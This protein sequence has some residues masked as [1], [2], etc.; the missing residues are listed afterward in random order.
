MRKVSVGESIEVDTSSFSPTVGDA[1]SKLTTPNRGTEDIDDSI[2]REGNSDSTSIPAEKGREVT[3]GINYSRPVEGN[4]PTSTIPDVPSGEHG[5]PLAI[6]EPSAPSTITPRPPS[7]Y[8]LIG[9]QAKYSPHPTYTETSVIRSTARDST[10]QILNFQIQAHGTIDLTNP[11][12]WEEVV[13]NSS[14][15]DFFEFFAKVSRTEL[16]TMR[17]LTFQLNFEDFLSFTI[18]RHGGRIV[19][20]KMKNTVAGVFCGWKRKNPQV[21]EFSI[22][23]KCDGVFDHGNGEL[24]SCIV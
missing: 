21:M 12:R 8:S 1:S 19:W 22:T 23:V 13:A 10:T 14:L 18:P 24:M 11:H 7:F 20:D 16:R 4:S 6:T 2:E 17:E 5:I 9:S 3:S 15:D